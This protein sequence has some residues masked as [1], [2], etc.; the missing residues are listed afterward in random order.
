MIGKVFLLSL[1]AG[2]ATVI[3][4]ILVVLLRRISDRFIAG[5]MGF[6][7]GV[8]LL[9]SFLNLFVESLE[10]ASYLY[11]SLA[12]TA[13]SIFMII[14]D[15]FLPH[16]ELGKK[17]D[18]IIKKSKQLK[19]G[20]LILIGITIHN[21][22]EGIVVSTGYAHLPQLGILIAIAVF[23]HNLP[24]GIAT[25]VS[26]ASGGS[27][28]RDV[29]LAVLISGL[30]EPFGALLGG[31]ILIGASNET[32][33][34][35]LAFAAG[36]MTYI[37]ADELIPIAGERGHKHVMSIGLLLGIIFMMILNNALR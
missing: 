1:F 20:I 23:F 24:E 15:L 30:A 11:V 25:A 9:V 37:T 32:I 34:L 16:L 3:G 12:F 33:G 21:I 6:A 19:P 4:G 5:S 27:R 14:I 17:E 26:L 10:L 2:S 8:M 35:A 22:P 7:S 36:V 18:G 31:T 28:K 13:G 29:V